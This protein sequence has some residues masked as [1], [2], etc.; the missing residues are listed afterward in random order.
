MAQAMEEMPKEVSR[1]SSGSS[2]PSGTK[3]WEPKK[4]DKNEAKEQKSETSVDSSASEK[5]SVIFE[6]VEEKKAKN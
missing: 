5:L 2:E 1:A 3:W 4:M 6:Q